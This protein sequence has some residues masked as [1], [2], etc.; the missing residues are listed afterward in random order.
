MLVVIVGVRLAVTQGRAGHRSAPEGDHSA[1]WTIHLRRADEARVREDLG[2]ADQAW[3]EAYRAARM[4]QRWEGMVEVGDAYL[5]IGESFGFRA[6]AEARARQLYLAA[7]FN[8]RGSG[9]LDGVLRAG[10]AFAVLGDRD[11]V[12][13]SLRVA[14]QLAARPRDTQAQDRVRAFRQQMTAR[15]PDRKSP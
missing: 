10:E 15:F 14:E 1:P 6:A 9:S 2:D 5:R 13:Q 4:S 11:V 3:R 8:A 7:L 12:E